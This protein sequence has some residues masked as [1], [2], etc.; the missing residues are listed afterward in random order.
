MEPE[1][2]AGRRIG[3][4]RHHVDA[5]RIAAFVAATGDTPDRWG[6]A[7]P[8]GYA[9]VLLFAVAGPFLFDP[10]LAP[11][12]RTLLHVDQRFDHPAPILA[13]EVLEI[14]GTVERVRE[15]AGAFLVVFRAEATGRDGPVLGARSTF[16]MSSAPAAEPG[17]DPGEPEATRRADSAAPVP[18]PLPAAGSVVELAKSASRA[19]LVRYAAATGDLNPIH[20]DHAAARAAGLEGIVVHGLL[21]HAWTS[22]LAAAFGEGPAPV[23]VARTRFRTPLRPAVPAVVRATVSATPGPGA[24]PA[25]DLAVLH[26]GAEL[27]ATTATIRTGGA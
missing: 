13:D 7:A 1:D 6:D 22:Q 3:P 24:G 26:D 2:L 21:L 15:R 19:D 4:V 9:A 5:E 23:R 8:P 11:H 12:T 17:A 20:W 14:V 10:R 16:L 27:V 18:R 25:V